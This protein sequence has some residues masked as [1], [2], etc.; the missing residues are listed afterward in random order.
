MESVNVTQKGDV[1]ITKLSSD[2]QSQQNTTNH[3]ENADPSEHEE[4]QRSSSGS[5]MPSFIQKL[6]STSGAKGATIMVQST[7]MDLTEM[8]LRKVLGGK[9]PRGVRYPCSLDLSGPRCS[10]DSIEDLFELIPPKALQNLNFTKNEI[11][12]VEI[13]RSD[14]LLR[15][16]R[17]SHN[18][19]TSVKLNLPLLVE[20]DLSFNKLTKFPSLHLPELSI[21]RLNNNMISGSCIGLIQMPKLKVIDLS[22][23]DFQWTLDIVELLKAV[24]EL[25]QLSDIMLQQG[26]SVFSADY[27]AALVHICPNLN[28]INGE[29]LTKDEKKP[30]KDSPMKQSQATWKD[31]ASVSSDTPST[32][33]RRSKFVDSLKTGLGW[34]GKRQ[35]AER[36]ASSHISSALD[37]TMDETISFLMFDQLVILVNTIKHLES[38]EEVTFKLCEFEGL[39]IETQVDAML[40]FS[41]PQQAQNQ[42]QDV[43]KELF[44][45]YDKLHD[46]ACIRGMIRFSCILY[47][48]DCAPEQLPDWLYSRH[49]L[50]D[51][52]FLKSMSEIVTVSLM[53]TELSAGAKDRL[54]K[55]VDD[56]WYKDNLL[57]SI[58]AIS[59]KAWVDLQDTCPIY[60][61]CYFARVS[62]DFEALSV[63]G[64]EQIYAKLLDLFKNGT[65]PSDYHHPYV[66]LA[67]G[68]SSQR[69]GLY[70]NILKESIN[71][72]EIVA[73]LRDC[74][75][76][77][78]WEDMTEEVSLKIQS[79]V[80]LVI[81]V[82]G[83]VQNIDG[84]MTL[85]AST[86]LDPEASASIKD[87]LKKSLDCPADTILA[88]SFLRLLWCIFI[89]DFEARDTEPSALMEYFLQQDISKKITFLSSRYSSVY[90]K[91]FI[92]IKGWLCERVTSGVVQSLPN[93]PGELEPSKLIGDFCSYLYTLDL[94][95]RFQ[96]LLQIQKLVDFPSITFTQKMTE[97]IAFVVQNN[98]SAARSPL[99]LIAALKL[100]SKITKKWKDSIR[101]RHDLVLLTYKVFSWSWYGRRTVGY[102]ESV[103]AACRTLLKD[104][105]TLA[106]DI[107]K[108]FSSNSVLDIC[109]AVLLSENSNPDPQSISWIETTPVGNHSELYKRIFEKI[110]PGDHISIRIV[111]QLSL[112]FEDRL[113]MQSFVRDGDY[114]RREVRLSEVG[115][116]PDNDRRERQ[117]DFYQ[118]Q[119]HQVIIEWIS[120]F[121]QDET[122]LPQ[123]DIIQALLS[124]KDT[125]NDVIKTTTRQQQYAKAGQCCDLA[126]RLSAHESRQG[127]S[128]IQKNLEH[129]FCESEDDWVY[130][131][132]DVVVSYKGHGTIRNEKAFGSSVE[133]SEL[134]L[135]VISFLLK[136]VW[137]GPVEHKT[138]A[139]NSL[140]ANANLVCRLATSAFHVHCNEENILLYLL[141]FLE[142]ISHFESCD[143]DTSTVVNVIK[144]GSLY[145]LRVLEHFSDSIQKKY[146]L[147]FEQ[148]R[149][150]LHLSN[151][152]RT[153][154]LQLAIVHQEC[155]NPM[156]EEYLRI[157]VFTALLP[158]DLC[159]SLID[160]LFVDQLTASA[161][162]DIASPSAYI[163]ENISAVVGEFLLAYES[164][165]YE[166]MERW[167]SREIHFG[168]PLNIATIKGILQY[169]REAEYF[170]AIRADISLRYRDM[171]REEKTLTQAPVTMY[172]PDKKS[173]ILV[174]GRQRLYLLKLRGTPQVPSCRKHPFFPHG[175]EIF[176]E[177]SFHS[178]AHVAICY[179]STRLLMAFDR[180]KVIIGFG[181][182]KAMQ[183]IISTLQRAY[184]ASQGHQLV[185]DM[186]A[187]TYLTMPS[188]FDKPSEEVV[189]LCAP[190]A[191]VDMRGRI[192]SA[193]MVLTNHKLYEFVEDVSRLLNPQVVARRLLTRRSICD[194]SYVESVATAENALDSAPYALRVLMRTG[195][196][197]LLQFACEH[198]METWRARLH[199]VANHRSRITLP[200]LSR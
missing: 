47:T 187:S 20:L 126:W 13:E 33:S 154:S 43:F 62:G 82:I 16:I 174:V 81:G 69:H 6:T 117:K 186:D 84:E 86:K 64:I 192:S 12:K 127:R 101:P 132:C 53:S 173:C 133:D 70:F 197:V 17:G 189:V 102:S 124:D 80:E 35:R 103:C 120:S 177:V 193:M 51:V 65:F 144:I 134:V 199:A 92:A 183:R 198:E 28:R 100:L 55:L 184:I 36:H 148:H 141:V 149:L 31:D 63:C 169:L 88:E 48:N 196:Q 156:L 75:D 99:V 60:A 7:I 165:Q 150:L 37:N 159:F 61:C 143:A 122:F 180:K 172:Y 21:L 138:R 153:I 29:L 71:L 168:V 90:Y 87:I 182:N 41:V 96:I 142:Q 162:P 178:I 44:R 181:G 95:L 200:S 94:S 97:A 151:F 83:G 1:F 175:L 78:T 190:L 176:T 93:P 14:C 58:R 171:L 136:L 27:K 108:E 105:S 68:R 130:E 140:K 4:R 191:K 107:S 115:D 116:Q 42:I 5:I 91:C 110:R 19:I 30:N 23:N 72:S 167:N 139:V 89:L 125:V 112:S 152:L 67:L 15:T 38:A 104:L 160:L 49:L 34:I 77:H 57:D 45:I 155:D 73:A 26:N 135:E 111:Q 76:S 22:N 131:P 113:D 74:L 164:N 39:L 121:I 24:E 195:A 18:L 98:Q 40:Q 106:G 128:P 59:S 179:D 161:N 194:L 170:Y 185:V 146:P 114:L 188:V 32:M 109:E 2:E 79:L 25:H 129:L 157:G 118:S 11:S 119:L 145:G 137:L 8:S 166:I 50:E 123:T 52:Y 9:D 163:R 56:F 10:L 54:M 3:D 85:R 46:G 66:T 147:S 158:L